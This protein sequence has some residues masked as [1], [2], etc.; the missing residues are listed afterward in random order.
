[1]TQ[2]SH[3]KDPSVSEHNAA[4][5][6]KL[7]CEHRL[8]E[9]LGETVRA[10]GDRKSKSHDV[11]LNGLPNGIGKM[12]SCRAQQLARIPWAKLAERIAAK[13]ERNEKVSGARVVKELLQDETREE[14]A[15]RLRALSGSGC[16]WTSNIERNLARVF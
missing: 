9:V 14:N 6:I 11:T 13:T 1:M 10:G 12:D 4:L 2:A 5:A 8:G 16:R 15:A 7:R 3:R